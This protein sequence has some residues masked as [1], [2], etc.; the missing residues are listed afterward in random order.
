MS[1]KLSTHWRKYICFNF[2]YIYFRQ[3]RS[4]SSDETKAVVKHMMQRKLQN[5]VNA[6]F[7]LWLSASFAKYMNNYSNLFCVK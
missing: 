2:V 6:M 1:T 5:K 7:C 4:S 3:S